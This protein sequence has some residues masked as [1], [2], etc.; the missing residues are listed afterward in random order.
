MANKFLIASIAAVGFAGAAAAAEF[1]EVDSDQNGLASLQEVQVI[2]PD[3]TQDDFDG[4]DENADGGLDEIEF[5]AWQ[6]AM[7][8]GEEQPY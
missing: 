6:T 2:A 3:V 7:N 8:G 4:Y 5:N 1:A